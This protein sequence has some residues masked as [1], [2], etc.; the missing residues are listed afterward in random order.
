MGF[1]FRLKQHVS[2]WKTV[3]ILTTCFTGMGSRGFAHYIYS[4]KVCG[5]M[6]HVDCVKSLLYFFTVTFALFLVFL[7]DFY[8]W[9]FHT[10]VFLL[11]SLTMQFSTDLI[12]TSC[13][14]TME[15]WESMVV[16]LFL[17]KEWKSTLLSRKF[18]LVS[19]WLKHLI[20]NSS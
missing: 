8:R 3:Y 12:P 18:L 9:Q 6:I 17:E 7:F 14:W 13:W 19:Y 10:T 1:S 15:L 4:F 2:S 11:T 16:K 20:D 5:G